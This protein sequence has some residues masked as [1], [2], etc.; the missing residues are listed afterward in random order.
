MTL[1]IKMNKYP[2]LESKTE[3]IMQF[4]QRHKLNP[5]GVVVRSPWLGSALLGLTDYSNLFMER[6]TLSLVLLDAFDNPVHYDR[7][8]KK[9][10]VGRRN[11]LWHVDGETIADNPEEYILFSDDCITIT[12]CATGSI[13][14]HQPI[15]T[16]TL[17]VSH[18]ADLLWFV[19]PKSWFYL[20]QSLD[21]WLTVE[22]ILN[23]TPSAVELKFVRMCASIDPYADYSDDITVWR[24]NNDNLKE[25][26]RTLDANPELQ[27]LYDKYARVK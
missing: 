6:N 4:I 16:G 2:T 7:F 9:G 17:L 10:I 25:I 8:C 19:N 24:G 5:K 3:Q 22:K 13:G 18:P 1:Y 20:H 26:K 14:T 27:V 23:R 11:M 21:T 12:P 15:D